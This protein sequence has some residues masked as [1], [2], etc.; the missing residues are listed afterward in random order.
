MWKRMCY[1]MYLNAK[2]DFYETSASSVYFYDNYMLTTGV[3][4]TGTTNSS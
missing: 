2:G 3:K 1:V 4:I